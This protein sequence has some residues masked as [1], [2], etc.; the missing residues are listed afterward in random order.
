M[1]LGDKDIHIPV[2]FLDL[3][4]GKWVR[5]IEEVNEEAILSVILDI[6][7]SE[8]K[9]ISY[10]DAIFILHQYTIWWTEFEAFGYTKANPVKNKYKDINIGEVLTYEQGIVIKSKAS[11]TL[12]YYMV[13]I[14]V[15]KQLG[16]EI[17]INTATVREWISTILFFLDAVGTLLN[18]LKRDFEIPHTDEEEM[19]RVD[20]FEVFGAYNSIMR[21]CDNDFL[22][23]NEVLM[24]PWWDAEFHLR[25]LDEIA[26]YQHDLAQIQKNATKK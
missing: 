16:C 25:Y 20:R 13:G 26:R 6:D 24:Q 15:I 3:P 9:R 21:L 7:V 2:S 5:L 23:R 11:D 10:N 17:D 14:E 12:G 18:K 1:K 4:I 22:K 19:A 8:V